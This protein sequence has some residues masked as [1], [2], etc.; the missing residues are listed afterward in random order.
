MTTSSPRRG[1][2]LALLVLVFGLGGCGN[3]PPTGVSGTV[4]MKG[5]PPKVPGLMIS[6]VSTAGTVV[7]APV[8]EDGTYTASGLASGEM[9]VGFAVVG[10]AKDK[11]TVD[12]Q[13]DDPKARTERLKAEYDKKLDP[14]KADP[15]KK[16]KPSEPPVKSPIPERYL[17]PLKSGVTTTLKPGD[18]TL[19][20]DIK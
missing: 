15:K 7:T 2:S 1:G 11:R 8:A 14:K 18:N 13:N 6:F 5:A 9:R 17:D 19:N 3:E 10:A 4:T 20:A 16:A 12:Q